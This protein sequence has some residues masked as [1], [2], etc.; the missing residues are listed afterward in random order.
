[1]A[2][3]VIRFEDGAAYER[4]MG[5][6]SRIAGAR[7]LDWL[8]APQG[9]RWVDVG[10]GN[11]AFTELV[12]E[13]CAPAAITG[14]D[15][16]DAQLKFARSRPG[17]PAATYVQGDAMALPFEAASFDVA[18]MALVLF[19]VPDPVRGVAELA[20]VTRPGGRAAAYNWDIAAGGLP[21]AP[22]GREMREMGFPAPSPPS[23]DAANID[24]MRELWQQAGFTQVETTTIEAPRTFDNFDLLWETCMLSPAMRATLLEQP[25]QVQAELRE[26]VRAKCTPDA[27]GRITW[28]GRANAV[29]G[30]RA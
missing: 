25:A 10:C 16:S 3:R 6:W 2:E 21:H 7:F 5:V 4:M 9:L 12:V 26:R 30:T 13:R 29:K 1:M 14:I 8:A 22:L 19:F 28:V 17:T 20:R 18:T 15:P 23:V 11:G 27:Q 24:R